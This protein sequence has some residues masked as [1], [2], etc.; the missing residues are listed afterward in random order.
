MNFD[1]RSFL[2]GLAALPFAAREL[3]M[4]PLRR[5]RAL[6]LIWLD[7]GMSHLDTFDAKPEASPAIRGDLGSVRCAVDGVFVSEHL[8]E[9]AR[10]LDRCALLRSVTH[11]EGNHDRGSHLLLTGHRPSPVLVHPALG[12]VFGHEPDA[13]LPPYVAIPQAVEYAGAGFLPPMRGPFV[14]GGDPGRADFAVRNLDA[15]GG[16]VRVQATRA[17]AMRTV[18]DE[19][20]GAP[21][22]AAEAQR[23]HFVAMATRLSEDAAARRWF[24]LAAEPAEQRARYGRHRLGQSCLLARRLVQGG[25]RTVLVTDTGWDHHQQIKTALTYGFPPKLQALD[26]AL[27]ALLDD[28]RQQQLD[29][30]VLVCVASE[31][32]RTPRLNPLGGRDHWPRAQSVL[33]YGAGIRP[34]VVGRTDARGEEPAERAIAPAE[35][36]ATLVAALGIDREL[37]LRTSDGRPVRLVADEAEPVHEVLRT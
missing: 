1:R 29:D 8:P 7:G 16:R 34:V 11:G 30:S 31:F 15:D 3:A 4:A 33:L 9:L 24:D 2:G 26:Q 14:V 36:F 23:D 35:V 12:A 21:R 27:S 6:I 5:P 20:D 17:Q 10:R 18:V 13:V 25:V 37:V 22:G 32:G 19:L 28:L